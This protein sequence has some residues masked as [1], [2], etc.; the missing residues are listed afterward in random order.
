ME[1]VAGDESVLDG[2]R[3]GDKVEE[4]VAI[5]DGEMSWEEEGE[6]EGDVE[7]DDSPPTFPL[8]EDGEEDREGGFPEGVPPPPLLALVDAVIS[9]V[10]VPR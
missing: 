2:D 9:G 7:P 5:E 1:A 10:L 6:G 4:L 8:L 3:R